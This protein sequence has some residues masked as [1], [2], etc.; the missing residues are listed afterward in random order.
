[1]KILRRQIEG[2]VL[3]LGPILVLLQR[4]VYGSLERPIMGLIVAAPVIIGGFSFITVKD[5]ARTE[6]GRAWCRRPCRYSWE[7][8]SSD[9]ARASLLVER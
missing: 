2:A 1:M 4:A 5:W 3:R 9:T 7:R 6:T 8:Y